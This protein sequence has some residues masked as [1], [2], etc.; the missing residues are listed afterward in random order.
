VSRKTDCGFWWIE[1][2]SLDCYLVGPSFSI[3]H[4]SDRSEDVLSPGKLLS[5]CGKGRRSPRHTPTLAATAT[6]SPV[7]RLLRRI[8]HNL[9]QTKHLL[10]TA[11]AAR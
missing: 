9:H 11:V 8:D 10:G 3:L 4:P 2:R 6:S 1:L 7:D 5:L